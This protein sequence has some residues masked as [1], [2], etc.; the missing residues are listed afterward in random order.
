MIFRSVLLVLFILSIQACVDSS[1]ESSNSEIFKAQQLDGTDTQCSSSSVPGGPIF[2]PKEDDLKDNKSWYSDMNDDIMTVKIT[3]ILR[4]G[5]C[6]VG[7]YSGC[8]IEDV[9]GDLNASD[10]FKPEVHVKIVAPGLIDNGEISN[11]ILTIKGKSTRN[12]V[13]KSYRVKLNSKTDLWK[14]ERYFQLNKHPYDLSRMRNKL[15]FDI[16]STVDNFAS[17]KTQFIHL[18]IDNIDYGL[19]THV[20]Y[21][22]KEY[23]KNHKFGDNDNIFKAQNFSFSVTD[24]LDLDIYAHPKDKKKFDDSI[25]LKNGKNYSKLVE[26]VYALN[27]DDSNFEEVFNKYFNFN[28]YI[29]WLAVNI[30]TE[31]IDTISQNFYLYNPEGTSKFYFLPW[32]YDGAWGTRFKKRNILAGRTIAK[33]QEGALRWWGIII[34]RK[35]LSKASNREL[36]RRAVKELREKYFNQSIIDERIETYRSLIQP[37]VFSDPDVDNLGTVAHDLTEKLQEW[38]DEVSDLYRRSVF[39]EEQFYDTLY[40]PTPFWI[41]SVYDGETLFISWGESYSFISSVHYKLMVASDP[42]FTESS[43][44]INI[45]S[46]NALSYFKSI[47]LLPGDYFIKVLSYDEDGEEQEAFNLYRDDEGDK[48]YGVFQLIV[49]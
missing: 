22:G 42:S 5:D 38:N 4:E 31:N 15:S 7:D 25:E 19:F 39:A 30:L 34:H 24:T 8:T 6:V 27:S 12:A 16:F 3:T 2:V 20:E 23:M 33:F 45:D 48:F 35:F 26:M 47:K 17:L 10:N 11:A 41:D 28:N 36:L 49:N 1:D 44:L 29:T 14:G 37:L 18:F 13:Q 43:L 46:T 40:R 32:D 21:I 9:N